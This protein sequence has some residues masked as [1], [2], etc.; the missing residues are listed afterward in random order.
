M[1]GQV[2]I[3]GAA[4]AELEHA[5]A[6]HRRAERQRH[7]AHAAGAEVPANAPELDV[8]DP[9]GVR[10]ESL[11]GIL[12]RVH[13]LIQAQ[14]RGEHR[15]ELGVV[16]QIVVRQRLLDVVEAELVELVEHAC[17]GQAIG[18]VG[19]DAERH[20]RQRLAHGAQ[21][22]HVPPRLDLELQP[23]VARRGVALGLLHRGRDAALDPDRRPH[24]DGSLDAAQERPQGYGR[25][26]RLEVPE[27]RLEGGHRHVVPA[28]AVERRQQLGGRSEGAPHDPRQDVVLESRPGRVR[29]L[30]AVTGNV[31][32]GDLSVP[33]QPVGVR[34]EDDLAQI[35]L[36]TE[37]RLEAELEPYGKLAEFDPLDLHAGLQAA[38]YTVPEALDGRAPTIRRANPGGHRTRVNRPRVNGPP[39]ERSRDPASG[40]QDTSE[41]QDTWGIRTRELRT[42][43]GTPTGGAAPRPP[44]T[45]FPR[46]CRLSLPV[47]FPDPASGR[48]A[49]RPPGPAS[50]ARHAPRP[51]GMVRRSRSD[52]RVRPLTFGTLHARARSRWARSRS[53]S[54]RSTS[55]RSLL[56]ALAAPP[57]PP[58]HARSHGASVSAR[59]TSTRS[60]SRWAR[61]RSASCAL[62]FPTLRFPAL[63]FPAL[64]LPTRG[65]PSQRHTL[66]RGLRRVLRRTAL[67]FGRVARGGS[68][69]SERAVSGRSSA[70]RGRRGGQIAAS[71]GG[72]SGGVRRASTGPST[73]A[74]GGAGG[75]ALDAPPERGSRWRVGRGVRR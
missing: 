63:G 13:R 59:S 1:R 62:R 57:A 40:S 4:D 61:S 46:R 35:L 19:I 64:A 23:L 31:A 3:V 74:S 39:P 42:R 75:A 21:R 65:I 50:A 29:G 69:R 70:T 16:H 66:P 53:A 8:D 41:R 10:L 54:R 20:A 45:A 52:R 25:G 30:I 47:A 60:A 71:F 34:D 43:R 49:S 55:R 48:G 28:D 37:T 5:A 44:P 18:A 24:F 22:L 72:A 51:I 7:V 67:P 2:Q 17:I 56:H 36:D 27:G 15:L 12:R 6:P 68:T 9:P 73:G 33:L 14:R 32:G 11:A 26:L 38:Q 58:H